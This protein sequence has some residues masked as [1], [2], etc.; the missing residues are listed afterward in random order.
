M[1]KLS[2]Y[3]I[4]AL[5]TLF[6]LT[7]TLTAG[8]YEANWESLGEYEI[9]EW[10][11]D[12]KLGIFIHWGVYSVPAYRSEWYPRMMYLDKKVWSAQGNI[13]TKDG[14]APDKPVTHVH[15]HHVTTYGPLDEFGYKNFIPMFKAENFDAAEWVS[16]FK[17]AGAKYVVPVAE[18]HDGFAMYD[19]NITRW[20]SVNMGPKR[21]ILGEI[22]EEA[23]KQGLYLGASSHFAFNW[24][25]YNKKHGWDTADPKYSDLY[26]WNNNPLEWV[27]DDFLELWW[28][29][30]KDIIDNYEPDILWFDFFIDKPEFVPYHPKLA[31]YYYNKGEEWGKEVVLQTKNFHDFKS[32]PEGTHVWD[33]ERGKLTDIYEYTWQTDTSIGANSWGYVTN[34]ISKTP[35]R[36]VDNLIDIVSKNGCLLLNVGPKADGTIPD[37]QKEVLLELGK[38][39]DVNGEAIYE[40][41][42]W[43]RFGEG[44][45][46]Q[47]EGHHSEARNADLTSKDKRFTTRDGNIYA[48]IMDWPEDGTVNIQSFGKESGYV[49]E[50]E[51]VAL[52]GYDEALSWGQTDSALRVSLPKQKQGDYAHT[53]VVREK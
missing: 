50:I 38:W 36:I 33:L 9:P 7:N 5:L 24:S 35:N 51:S 2:T 44:P 6:S 25:Y 21:D 20:D 22:S 17:K 53:L 27:D 10:F 34:W 40:S 52:L 1:R 14:R 47:A 42:P 12:A 37:D 46:E 43:K 49:G 39:L 13:Q 18:H 30:T 48:I 4:V 3:S 32:Y 31:A 29:R 8:K 41:R 15:E 11:T 16:L 28:A 26:G 23:K 19:S 45:T